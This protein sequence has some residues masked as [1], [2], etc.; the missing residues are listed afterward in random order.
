MGS[1]SLT[2]DANL[3]STRRVRPLADAGL[4]YELNVIAPSVD[5][6][7]AFIGGWL[8]DRSAAGWTVNVLLDGDHDK[9]PLRILGVASRE[10]RP[11]LSGDDRGDHRGAGLAVASD[12]RGTDKRIEAEVRDALRSSD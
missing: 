11:W 1:R 9:H 10:L 12:L 3:G 7:V 2:A 8:F 4:R 6:V 5:D